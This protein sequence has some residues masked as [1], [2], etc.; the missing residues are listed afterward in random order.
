MKAHPYLLGHSQEGLLPL[1]DPPEDSSSRPPSP[2][3]IILSLSPWS[4]VCGG[5]ETAMV[6]RECY[7]LWTASLGV[8]LRLPEFSAVGVVAEGFWE[9]KS[10]PY[11]S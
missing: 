4:A 7:L 9:M 1:R 2:F 5:N 3:K 8:R 6:L 11:G 10:I